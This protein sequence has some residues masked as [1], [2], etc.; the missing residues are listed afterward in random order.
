MG[1][2]AQEPL[3]QRSRAAYRTGNRLRGL[4]VLFL[5][6]LAAVSFP[7]AQ[8]QQSSDCLTCHGTSIGL[9]N[10][11]GKDIAVNPATH[12][13][14]PHATLGCVDCHAGAA[15][16]T[17][18]A[19]TAS[20]SCIACHADAATALAS[21]AHAALGNP[22]SS[23]TCIACH[24][25]ANA[26]KAVAGTQF[27]ATCHAT[28]V[29]QYKASVHGH[30]R[31]LGNADVPTC[32]SCH[33]SAHTVLP[34][35]DPQSPVGKQRLPDTCGS[36]HSDP[37][38]AAKYMFGQ[39]RP[40]DAWRQSVH[41]RAIAQGNL[42]AASCSDCHG[43][44]DI[45]PA[46]D[47]RSK[48]WKQ[49]V[50]ATCGRCHAGVY[51]TYASSI[52]GQALARG[53]LQAATCTDCHS[54]HK[55][56]APG[57]PGSAV[58]MANVSQEACSRCHADTRLMAG[59]NLPQD[60][61]PTYEDSYHGL[62]SREGGQTV[63]NCASCHGIHNI[64][65]SSDPR[66]TVN[67]ANLGKTCGQCHADA[68]QRFA[69]GPVHVLASTTPGGRALA[70]VRLFYF[71]VI[72]V[73]LGLMFLHNF[74]D[75][76]RKAIAALARYR[77]APGQL[78]LNRNERIQHVLLLSSFIVLVITGF[79]LKFPHAF[80][81]VPIV[82]WE[83]H[84]PIR[85]W[86]HRI[87]GVVLI[88]TS[89]WHILY[90]AAKRS[91]RRWFRDMAPDLRDAKEAVETVEYNLGRRDRLPTYRRFNYAEKA[92]YWAL[93]WGTLVMAITG[94]LLWLN[95]WILAHVPHPAAI[96]DVS[97]A[98]HFYEAILATLAIVIWHFYAVLFD[99]DIYPVKWTFL[100]GHAP[101]H[102]HREAA[103][104][105]AS[106]PDSSQASAP[107]GPPGASPSDPPPSHG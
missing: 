97:T 80:W 81:V 2:H 30:A 5:G 98:I 95:N 10:S 13:R 28:E 77:R 41:G 12:M 32:Q 71:I 39:V 69:I 42:N 48:I 106:P 76:R 70:F 102:E 62:A 51:Q 105:V 22:N 103:E 92:E 27:C 36:C 18:N 63:A 11:S 37:K 34:A 64:Y 85:G 73:T 17:H 82:R 26:Q 94:V 74:L 46:T 91:G 86:V 9:K 14:G 83:H 33:G 4:P 79:A 84:I 50:A 53:V 20:A 100:T 54:E 7:R 23:E 68:G 89:I 90:L 43:T 35:S 58:Y 59:F 107:P 66:S 78:R 75:W 3:A 56:L 8:A 25:T 57:N 93:V 65:A 87:A 29:E 21:S 40:V 101:E 55:I 16:E 19:K 31:G 99:P 60:R 67:R 52:H 49:N 44:H 96:L 61:V 72:P 38:L 6:L 45:L 1:T 104:D 24:G 88:A 47:P 15:A